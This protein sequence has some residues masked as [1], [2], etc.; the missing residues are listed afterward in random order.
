MVSTA[1]NADAGIEEV[2]RLLPDVVLM[3]IN[4]PGRDGI[5]ATEILVAEPP[6]SA[7]VLM[8]VQEDREYLRRAMQAGA[9]EFLVKPFSGDELVGALRRVHQLELVKKRQQ[10]P[11]AGLAEAA[12]G[13]D[14]DADTVETEKRPGTIHLVFSGKGGVGKSMLAINLAA[15]LVRATGGRVALVDFDLQFGDVGVLLGLDSGRNIFQVVEAYPNV[16]QDFIEALMPEAP[17]GFRVLL[18][19]QSPEYADLVSLA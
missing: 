11:E 2:R 1:L 15:T 5:K 4:M 9:R 13:G 12:E 18:C 7:V 19:P 17:G 6:H 10:E 16:D 3:D 14:G 8:S